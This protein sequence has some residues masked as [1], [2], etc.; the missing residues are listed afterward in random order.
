[1]AKR[2]TCLRRGY[3]AIIVSKDDEIISSGFN[4]SARGTEDCLQRGVCKRQD[5]QIPSGERYE[6]CRSIHGE[7]NAIISAA[8]RD[9]VGSTLYLSGIDMQTKEALDTP[10]PCMLCRRFIINAGIEKVVM[11]RKDGYETEMVSDW[12]DQE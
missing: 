11:M 7:Q 5:L 12:V 3:G 2:A 8:R 6:L 10:E 4:G 1:M 9:M